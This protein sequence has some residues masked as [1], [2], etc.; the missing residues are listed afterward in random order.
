[1]KTW[2][3][4]TYSSTKGHRSV[5]PSLRGNGRPCTNM[6]MERDG[7]PT[8]HH[9]SHYLQ[10]IPSM[11]KYHKIET[12][13]LEQFPLI[14]H[15]QTTTVPI[16][17]RPTHILCTYVE[18]W[19]DIYIYSCITHYTWFNDWPQVHF[20]SQESVTEEGQTFLQLHMHV[21]SAHIC[22]QGNSI[23]SY[24][25]WYFNCCF[26]VKYFNSLSHTCTCYVTCTHSL[27]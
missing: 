18:T 13:A 23:P 10:S 19:V 20:T 8:S 26:N 1:M 7:F 15:Q 4:F 3:L 5:Q 22:T 14:R 17:I 25:I 16:Y 27:T 12:T 2:S 11:Q 24:N 6:W 21:Y 9:H